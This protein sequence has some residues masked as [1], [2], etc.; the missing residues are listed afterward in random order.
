MRTFTFTIWNDPFCAILI[1]RHGWRWHTRLGCRHYYCGWTRIGRRGVTKGVRGRGANHLAVTLDGPATEP[2]NHFAGHVNPELV[3]VSFLKHFEG[4]SVQIVTDA[5]DPRVRS[6]AKLER[7]ASK[8]SLGT[9]AQSALYEFGLIARKL[10]GPEAL[11]FVHILQDEEAELVLQSVVC[12]CSEEGLLRIIR[13]IDTVGA[14]VF[15]EME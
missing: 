5:S 3:V 6:P 8:E 15:S 4:C 9:R 10:E 1:L 2:G 7:L 11:P 13:R 12:R 14:L